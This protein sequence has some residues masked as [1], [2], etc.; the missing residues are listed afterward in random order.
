MI[1]V[2]YFQNST[3][4]T[5][6]FQNGGTWQT[7]IKPRNAKMVS[8]FVIGAGAGG[9]G[10]FQTGS[11]PLAGGAGGGGSG[12]YVRLAVQASLLPDILYILPGTGGAGGIGGPIGTQTSGSSATKSFVCLIP[13]TG[14]IS[15][16]VCT[17][18]NVAAT[19]GGVG[20]ST[21]ATAAQGAAE[22][23][24]TTANMVFANL[25]NFTANAGLNGTIGG[26]TNATTA[27]VSTFLTAAT[28][29]GGCGTAAQGLSGGL[30]GAGIFPTIAATAQG[31]KGRD[32]IILYKPAFGLTGGLGGGGTTTA[33]PAPGGN[34]GNGAPGCGG[35]GGGGGTIV[36]GTGNGGRGGDGLIMITTNF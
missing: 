13:D 26:I 36:A 23:I 11:S 18:G 17:S 2:S 22:S 28:G 12:G 25:G 32:G 14:S 34:G 1:D 8:F 10:A 16:V 3:S 29:G 33:T 15:N 6:I 5:Q 19:G 31:V 30:T 35:G 7:W 4:N 24:A 27:T 21:A 20:R 9:G